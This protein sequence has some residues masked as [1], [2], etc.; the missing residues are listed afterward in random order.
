MPALKR[1]VIYPIFLKCLKYTQ[2]SFW[3]NIFEELAYNNCTPG[4][5]ISKGFYCSSVKGKEFVYKFLD[6]NENIIF[7]DI[8]KLLRDKM[9]VMSKNDRKTLLM[10]I[11]VIEKEL[12][13]YKNTEWGSIKKKS[14]KENF[15]QDYLIE[16]KRK[17][18]LSDN[19]IKKLYNLINLGI[20]LKTIK[21]NDIIYE[22]GK[23]INI[24]GI[25]FSKN[26]YTFNIDI[27]SSLEESKNLIDIKK[28]KTLKTL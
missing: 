3:Y 10:E 18:D 9:N 12:Q 1:E 25:S 28:K 23:I 5:F 21:N 15:I 19:Q 26:K 20:M 24:K 7:D 13:C 8:T 6:K 14:I 2:D 17:N 16:S 22:D 27:Y 4:S 11:D